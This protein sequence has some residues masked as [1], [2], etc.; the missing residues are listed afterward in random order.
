M[1]AIRIS[2]SLRFTYR[3]TQ[4]ILLDFPPKVGKTMYAARD[5]EMA[6]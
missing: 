2:M 3:V 6:R 1:V 4:L 5:G